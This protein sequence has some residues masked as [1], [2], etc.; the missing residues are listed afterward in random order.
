MMG[1]N[2]QRLS[3]DKIMKSRTLKVP[4]G[5]AKH[6]HSALSAF[7]ICRSDKP[8][9]NPQPVG[10]QIV[11]H[12]THWMNHMPF[13]QH[14]NRIWT[15]KM[16]SSQGG[17]LANSYQICSA[18]TSQLGNRER[19]QR[20]QPAQAAVSQ[21]KEAGEGLRAMRSDGLAHHTP[22]EK[23]LPASSPAPAQRLKAARQW[24]SRRP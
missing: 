7:A 12:R 19:F 24:K 14:A 20:V 10:Y 17:A 13:A 1:Q 3:H 15:T 4:I 6:D 8:D 11:E 21:R 23:A 18:L 9:R 22:L 5:P 16:A 2:L